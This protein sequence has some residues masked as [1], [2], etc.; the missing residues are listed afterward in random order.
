MG[1]CI[2]AAARLCIRQRMFGKRI[3]RKSCLCFY[4]G[5]VTLNEKDYVLL[6]DREDGS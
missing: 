6:D 1:S 4:L 2:G 5:H 3:V